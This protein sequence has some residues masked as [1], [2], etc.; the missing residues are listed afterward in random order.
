MINYEEPVELPFRLPTPVYGA[1]LC[2]WQMR[3]YLQKRFPLQ[4][5]DK[6]VYQKYL[7]W[8]V[9]HGRR[10]YKALMQ[11][12]AWD[13]A[14][15]KPAELPQLHKDPFGEMFTTGM[16]LLGI[17][18][19]DEFIWPLYCNVWARRRIWRWYWTYLRVELK[20]PIPAWQLNLIGK[21]YNYSIGE[22]LL[23]IAPR[24]EWRKFRKNPEIF[25]SKYNLQRI[26][27]YFNT[28]QGDD[29]RMPDFSRAGT[30]T[31]D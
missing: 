10:E 14:L 31:V 13:E 15:N 27:E 16:C 22:L 21:F 25:V 30:G 8:C 12:S 7:A 28:H 29:N 24:W 6:R 4:N 3:P 26:T 17:A 1:M 2:V 5:N 11:L 23:D 18:Q 9:M 19:Y 20:L